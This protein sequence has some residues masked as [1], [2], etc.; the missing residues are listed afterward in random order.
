MADQKARSVPS[1]REGLL[2]GLV[3]QSAD[4]AE[5]A[6]STW[7]GVAR[8]IRDQVD[9]RITGTLSWIEG[10]QQG[11]M[12]LA[13]GINSRMKKRADDSIDAFER[14]AVGVVRATRDT[15]RGVTDWATSIGKSR[16]KPEKPQPR[17][18]A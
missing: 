9:E 18:S 17:A 15:S 13:R 3:S 1:D 10:T 7:F 12:K 8:D 2:G 4:L 16:E 5:K 14:M 11:V 6:T